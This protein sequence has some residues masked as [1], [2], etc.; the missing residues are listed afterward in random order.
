MAPPT[1]MPSLDAFLLLYEPMSPS[2]WRRIS[3]K[4]LEDTMADKKDRCGLIVRCIKECGL[5]GVMMGYLCR[6]AYPCDVRDLFQDADMIDEYWDA[7]AHGDGDQDDEHEPPQ[8]DDFLGSEYEKK[9]QLVSFLNRLGYAVVLSPLIPDYRL[10]FEQNMEKWHSD[11]RAWQARSNLKMFDP[12]IGVFPSGQGHEAKQFYEEQK[13]HVDGMNRC[14][15]NTELA[16][17]VLLLRTDLWD[18]AR[19]L[20]SARYIVFFWMKIASERAMHPDRMDMSSELQ[21][22]L[23]AL[24]GT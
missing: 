7:N 9:L 15:N 12:C 24:S 18:K 14:R 3:A 20:I 23:S 6:I 5:D 16:K 13:G 2:S 21:S 1:P 17:P 19:A 8:L 4:H 22:A 10:D 11:P